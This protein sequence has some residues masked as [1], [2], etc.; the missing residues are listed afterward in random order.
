MI[1][2]INK[3][4]ADPRA[5]RKMYRIVTLMNLL[6]FAGSI[7]AQNMMITWD[8]NPEAD[9][10]GYKVYYG[11]A[12]RSY[13]TAVDVGSSLEFSFDNIGGPEELYVAVTAYDTAGNESDFS[14][15]LVINI[16]QARRQFTLGDGYPNPFNPTVT[17]PYTLPTPMEVDLTVFNLIGRRVRALHQGLQQAGHYAAIWDGTD[18]DGRPVAAGTYFVCLRI[19]SFSQTKRIM[20]LR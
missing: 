13:D 14:E 6:I 9:L 15:E 8:A 5:E 18:I 1:P 17:I 4:K 19:G 20:L 10:S 12:S 11:P 3:I 2:V 16:N 7:S